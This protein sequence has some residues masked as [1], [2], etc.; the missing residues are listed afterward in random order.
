MKRKT[1]LLISLSFLVIFMTGCAQIGIPMDS[2][3]W[4]TN[5]PIY[6]KDSF[7][8]TS[9]GWMPFDDDIGFAGYDAGGFRLIAGFE[10]YQFWSVPGLN[11][12][13]TMIFTRAKKIDGP[14]NNLFGIICRYQN[15]ANFYALVIGSDGYYGI[16]KTIGGQQSLIAQEHMDF[17]TVIHQGNADNEIQALCQG[18]DLVLLVNGEQLIHVKDD[19]LT[20]GDI[21]L[22]VGN[23]S[24]PGTDII[25][26]NFIVAKP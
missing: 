1:V 14:E 7:E 2:L 24:Q 3:P 21:G 19:S 20:N 22:I 25:F 18:E 9:G 17:S 13:D 11:F 5:N 23:F 12:R 15:E 10:N 8:S 6:F 26:D 16:F 4:V